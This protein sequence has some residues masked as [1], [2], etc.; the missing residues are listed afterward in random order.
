MVQK[1]SI[2]AI[3]EMDLWKGCPYL[4]N[5]DQI[6][7]GSVVPDKGTNAEGFVFQVRAVMKP[8]MSLFSGI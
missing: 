7:H 1:S 6:A 5:R 8:V 4:E 2:I 3:V